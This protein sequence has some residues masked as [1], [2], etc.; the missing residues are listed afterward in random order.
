MAKYG[1]IEIKYFCSIKNATDKNY[2]LG[3]ILA[4]FFKSR[5][6]QFLKT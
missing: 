4:F 6:D 2:Y 3:E 5:R 1:Y